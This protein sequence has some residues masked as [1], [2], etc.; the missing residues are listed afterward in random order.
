MKKK[1]LSFKLIVGGIFLVL[2]PLLFVGIFS[3]SKASRSLDSLAK[4]QAVN[5]AKDL[6]GMT[7]LA[8]LEELKLAK[9]ISVAN[10]TV[11]AATAMAEKGGDQAAT[12][13]EAVSA[14]LSKTMRAIGND[15]ESIFL[16]DANGIVFADGS[17]GKYKG[18]SLADRPYFKIAKQGTANIASALKSQVTGKPVAPVSVPV[19]SKTGQFIGTVTSALKL[20]FIS[21]KINAVKVGKTG[22]PFMVGKDGM[23]ISHPDAK[24]VL[25]TNLS[26]LKGMEAFVGKMMSQQTGVDGYVFDGIE[27]I[28]GYAPVALTGWSIGVTQP[29]DEFLAAAKAIRN[30]ILLVGAIFM[31]LTI[32]AVMFFARSVSKPINAVIEG[33]NEG[34]EQV[35]SASGQISSAGQSMAEG[36]SEQAASIEETSSSLEEM[37]S[38]TKQN[39]DNASQADGL[40]KESNKVVVLANESMQKLIESMRDISRASEETSKIIKTIDEISFQTNLLALNAAVE[41]ARAGEA[42][43]GFAVV[44]DEVRNLAMRAADAAKNT[45]GLI[46]DTVRKI[47]NGSEIVTRTNDAFSKV[48]VSASKVGELVA[49]ISAASSEQAQGI[50]QVNTAVAEMDKV[51]QQNAANAEESASAAEE[52]NAQAEQMKGMVADLITVIAGEKKQDGRKASRVERKS[53]RPIR[54]AS[55]PVPTRRTRPEQVIPM[56]D[57]GFKDF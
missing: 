52:M 55:L 20:D 19:L 11:A 34:A 38:M 45:A 18:V 40:M 32:I 56:D 50:E 54:N 36:A 53:V 15:Y 30:V 22:F 16:A 14:M 27:K 4:E 37:S 24:H 23:T 25:E 51:V 21:E 47:H 42:G 5:L 33:L 48:A 13:L 35:V 9:Q 1:S 7:Q 26:R 17:N 57:D 2:F 12:A 49:E 10:A 41:A 6:A 46:E 43:A 44:A 28:A 39:A 31:A 3:V 8:L 29:A